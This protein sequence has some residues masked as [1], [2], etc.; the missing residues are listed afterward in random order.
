MREE[1]GGKIKGREDHE[2]MRKGCF[3]GVWRAEIFG[4]WEVD[5]DFMGQ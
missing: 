3:S 5:K 1:G 2:T 4:V